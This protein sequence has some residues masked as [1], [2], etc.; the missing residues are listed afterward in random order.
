MLPSIDAQQ[1][2]VLSYDRVLVG[3]RADLDLA[4]FVVLNEPGP[5]AAL[6]AGEC[7]V[8]FG[9]EVG[10]G[11]VGGF[12]CCLFIISSQLYSYPIRT[13]FMMSRMW[14]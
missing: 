1:R 5:T 12:D 4:G 2:C 3:I 11:A 13:Y 9:L 8:E 10:E 6:D 7:S 14:K